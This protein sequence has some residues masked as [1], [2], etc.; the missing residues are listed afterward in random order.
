MIDRIRIE[1]GSKPKLAD[2]DP[3]DTLGLEDKAKAARP[4]A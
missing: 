1:P 3:G 2:R 4:W